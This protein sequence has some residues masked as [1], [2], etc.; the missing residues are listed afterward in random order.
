VW[1]QSD[2][3]EATRRGIVRNG[4][5]ARAAAGWADWMAEELPFIAADRPWE[6]AVAVVAGTPDVEHDLAGHIVVAPVSPGRR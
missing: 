6:R 4:G 5:D 1:V 2:A 3:V